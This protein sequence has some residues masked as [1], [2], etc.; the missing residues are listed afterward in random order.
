M[1]VSESVDESPPAVAEE[2][3]AGVPARRWFRRRRA[4]GA[5]AAL[6][7]VAV[8]VP[9]GVNLAGSDAPRARPAE[10]AGAPVTATE[11][12][13]LAAESGEEVEV[14]ADRGANTTTWAQPGG[15]FRMRVHSAAFRAEA[16]GEW[17]PV[18]TGLERVEGGYAP[19]AVNSPVLFSAGSPPRSG[20]EAPQ[21]GTDAPQAG[22]A[23]QAA[24]G[25]RASRGASGATR[26]SLTTAKAASTVQA[27]TPTTVPGETWTELARLK[28][29]GHEVVV[30]WPGALPAP[31][32]DGPRALYEGVRPGIDLL[33]TAQ[34]GG[35]SHLLIVKD[36][37]A[38]QDPLL[39]RL[40]YRLASPGLA[41]RLDEPSGAVGAFDSAGKEIA[42]APSPLMWDSAGKVV[43]TIGEPQPTPGEAARNH[44][45]LALPGILGAE[46]AHT[47]VAKAAL[48]ADNTLTLT[49]DR[50]LLDDTGTVY[51][52]FVDPSFKGRKNSWTLLYKTEG[53]SS[54][55][56]GQ[57]YN[58]SGTNEARVGYES[59]SGGTS[60]SVFNF[61]FDT[62][63]RGASI[64]SAHLRALQTYSWSCQARVFDVYSTPYITSS[65][66]W[67]NTNNGSFWGRYTGSGNSGSGYN[68][69]CPDNWTG[70]D[71]WNV[72]NDAATHGWQAI[73]LGLRAQN[74][75]DPSLWKKFL[76]NGESAPYIEIVYNTPPDTPTQASMQISPGGTCVVD[77]PYP[78]L[79]KTDLQFQAQGSDRDGNLKQVVFS[80]WQSDTG[81]NVFNEHI[82]PDSHGVARAPVL[83]WNRF[84]PGKTY[85]WSAW[86]TDW[87][88][89]WSGGGPA[90][91][92]KSC[93][94]T[95]DHTAPSTPAV[96]SQDFP[97][98]GPDG[99]EWS[100]NPLG[101]GKATLSA[102]GYN[103]ADIRE[104][105]W[106]LNHPVFNHKAVPDAAGNAVIDITPDNAG[107]NL[108][109]VRTVSKAGNVSTPV[110]YVFYV[111]PKDG[112]DTP[113]DVTGDGMADI[114]A[115]DGA[116]D[117]RVYPGDRVGD[118]DPWM[119]AA[120]DAGRSVPPGYWKDPVTGKPAL[121]AHS[122]DWF[123][124]DGLTDLLARMPDGRLYVYPGD[125]NGRFDISRRTEI[126]LPAGAPDPATLTQLVAG[127]D[128]TGDGQPD[129]FALAGDRFWGFSGYTGASFTE[130]HQFAVG[131]TQRDLIGVRD[132]SGDTIPDLLFR[133]NANPNRGLALRAGRTGADGRLDL[134]SIGFSSNEAGKRDLA[135]ATTGW[136]RATVP[137]LRG[138]PDVNND[139]IPDLYFIR[140]D[141]TLHLFYGGNNGGAP[142]LG[143]GW[144]VDEEGWNAFPAIG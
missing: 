42:G 113:G 127:E 126:L 23:S 108:L 89:Q 97:L 60:R 92:N 14:T 21:A 66:T 80:I 53:S 12:R 6:L 82:W 56:N 24:A 3:R 76:A 44:P 40:T 99:A 11:A 15:A 51:P 34:D 74:E 96:Q 27:A 31:V 103:P 105:E 67:N 28:V 29:D 65:T 75:S 136:E 55:Y 122:T 10:Q 16:G 81:A 72:A 137:L 84:T 115:V 140:T 98:P 114:I 124:G 142:V 8:A 45:S 35:Y 50:R 116:G 54:F 141:G 13:R 19:K 87:N 47:A 101:P 9:V 111:R 144:R 123:P 139:G 17:K 49:P 78:L 133:D 36:R 125:G 59:T 61:D 90:G 71:I 102:N 128:V 109:Y 121:I 58:A 7:A 46:G 118:I 18:D 64:H 143:N 119:P 26:A 135:Y 131:W 106:S 93:G 134:A 48:A 30:T 32:V 120:T 43:T 22:P 4:V 130:A 39:S 63:L 25:E 37:Q 132:V 5:L 69:S 104:F 2:K 85:F 83:S 62:K 41:F 1:S 20:T 70:V 79:G 33:M 107:P 86:S 112:Q 38:A 138:T 73:S 52:V 129:A 77:T 110:T 100:R 95:V 94:F 88:D 91:L 68:S 117:L 57:N